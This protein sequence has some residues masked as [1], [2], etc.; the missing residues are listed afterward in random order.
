MS[1]DAVSMDTYEGIE[2]GIQAAFEILG[3]NVAMARQQGNQCYAQ[4]ILLGSALLQAR[5]AILCANAASIQGDYTEALQML[6]EG[7][8]LA[9]ELGQ[10]HEQCMAYH[11]FG[12]TYAKLGQLEQALLYY[13]RGMMLARAERDV[14][15]PRFLNNMAV[16]YSKQGQF[17]RSLSFLEESLMLQGDSPTA[18]RGFLLT[19]IAE[20]YLKLGNMREALAYNERADALLQGDNL[21]HLYRV[22]CEK[23]YGKLYTVNGQL[24]RALEHMAIAARI[25]EEMGDQYRRT[26]IA[27]EI[28]KVYVTHFDKTQAVLRLQE[29]LSLA[30]ACRAQAE[31]KEIYAC[32]SQCYEELGQYRESLE[33]L[34]AYN[35]LQQSSSTQ[36]FE[37]KLAL[38]TAELELERKQ[39]QRALTGEKQRAY[40]N[41]GEMGRKIAGGHSLE[42]VVKAIYSELLH[43]MAINALTVVY[44][45]G[46]GQRWQ[47]QCAGSEE[48]RELGRLSYRMAPLEAAQVPEPL[49]RRGF[50][51]SEG[52]FEEGGQ[53]HGLIL[54]QDGLSG[55]LSISREDRFWSDEHKQLLGV[56]MSYISIALQNAFY[57]RAL[58]AQHEATRV[59]S[60]TDALTGLYNRRLLNER[61]QA[62]EALS[63]R[64]GKRFA[65]A[66]IDLDRFKH[67]NDTHGHDAGDEVLLQVAKVLRSALRSYDVLGRWGGEEF[68]VL[69]PDTEAKEALA[70]CERLRKMVS[71]L[72]IFYGHQQL[73]ITCTIGVAT[74]DNTDTWEDVM[75]LADTR[76]YAGK[77]EGR[78]Q[79]K[80]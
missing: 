75:R 27:L 49:R 46:E 41:I 3:T 67:I 40:Q 13:E 16:I 76:L 64:S 20:V 61:F 66:L 54:V 48:S 37:D 11:G 74:S 78:N 47:I 56:L 73:R 34:K 18:S 57:S 52:I 15:L 58:K 65:I 17:E 2:A 4:S 22:Q 45:E 68:A 51:P 29:A 36:S 32:L 43:A 24:D 69:F 10:L 1:N 12:N 8:R 35:E 71:E 33:A 19:N 44:L 23:V 25:C 77:A 53:L 30:M 6:Q 79:V 28:A 14:Y 31:M 60:Y 62:V 39:R 59:L 26:T 38:K 50:Q 55:L 63:R 5:A 9:V 7:L 72:E 42:G 70:S 21:D 80:G